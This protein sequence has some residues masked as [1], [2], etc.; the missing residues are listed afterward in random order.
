MSRRIDE[1]VTA[2]NGDP[3][4]ALKVLLLVNEQFEHILNCL[5]ARLNEHMRRHH[6]QQ[7]LHGSDNPDKV[8]GRT[9]LVSSGAKAGPVA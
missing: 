2:C 9:Q 5:N 3:R 6:R 4:S 7:A 1:V 8:G